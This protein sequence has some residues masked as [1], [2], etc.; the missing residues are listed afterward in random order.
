LG[1]ISSFLSLFCRLTQSLH[2]FT[3]FKTPYSIELCNTKE[4]VL[5]INLTFLKD[6]RK[7]GQVW[8]KPTF[9]YIGILDEDDHPTQQT[10]GA[11]TGI[12]HL[13]S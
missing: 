8:L 13:H 11:S 6:S 7:Y 1:W 4:E 5:K 9:T 3:S 10:V 2:G 12:Y